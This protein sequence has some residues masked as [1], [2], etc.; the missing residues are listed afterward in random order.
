MTQTTFLA[1]L[2]AHPLPGDSMAIVTQP[3]ATGMRRLATVLLSAG[4]LSASLLSATLLSGCAAVGPDFQRPGVPQLRGTADDRYGRKPLVGTVAAPGPG[5]AAQT[6]VLGGVVDREWW[7]ALGS[8]ALNQLVADALAHNPTVEAMQAAL[9]QARENVTA[10]EGYSYP[11]LTANYTGSRQKNPTGTIAPTLNSGDPLY[12]LHTAQF[13]VG[14]VPDVLG[15]NRRAVESLAA[16]VE[17]QKYQM[18]AAAITLSANVVSTVVM[19]AT[20][21]DQI[22]ATRDIIAANRKVLA[23]LRQQLQAGA[24]SGMEIAAQETA[25]AQAEQL[26]PPLEKQ[27]EQTRD[28][29]AVLVGHLPSQETGARFTLADLTLPA[30]LPLTVPSRLI[31]QRPDVR[32]AEAQVHVASAQVGVA[33][34]N[35]LPQFLISGNVGGTATQIGQMFAAGNT[36]WALAGSATQTLYDFGTLKARQRGAEAALDQSVAT[37]RSVA[38]VAFQNVADALYALDQDAKAY[39]AAVT[40][41]TA[42]KRSYDLTRQQLDLGF[43]NLPALL[44]AE[45]A[46]TQTRLATVQAFGARLGDSAALFLALGGGANGD[47]GPTA[48]G[49]ALQGRL[50]QEDAHPQSRVG[51]LQAQGAFME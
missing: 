40:A 8:P 39:G 3:Q 41:E 28:A 48:A 38:L 13:N 18:D 43:V 35:R 47:A 20:V 9:R 29:L 32:A 51:V 31:E 14:F 34:A 16:Q 36:F 37:Y 44:A 46:Y 27:A 42:A 4:V 49:S 10:Q 24:V 5:G 12:N 50:R 21:T 1:R 45:Q 17:T 11:T 23:L 2:R 33:L 7:K 25:V 30:T 15:M 6:L 26:L 22:Q 19:L